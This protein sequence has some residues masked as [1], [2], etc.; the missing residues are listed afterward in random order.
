M[1]IALTNTNPVNNT[2]PLM[3]MSERETHTIKSVNHSAS[4]NDVI[5]I[6]VNYD[7]TTISCYVNETLQFSEKITYLSIS[8]PM[9]LVF[10]LRGTTR[11]IEI[12]TN[13]PK[14]WQRE[15]SSVMEIL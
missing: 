6:S 15:W 2:V 12:S 4:V 7:A 3:Q 5:C 10:D 13:Q 9:W 14:Y 11:A 8:D 1:D